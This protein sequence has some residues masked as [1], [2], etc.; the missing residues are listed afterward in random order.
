MEYTS[1]VVWKSGEHLYHETGEIKSYE[2]WQGRLLW[3]EE[4]AY[5]TD[6]YARKG[7]AIRAAMK[8]RD[9]RQGMLDRTDTRIEVTARKMYAANEKAAQESFARRKVTYLSAPL[10]WRALERL[11]ATPAAAFMDQATLDLIKGH[12]QGVADIIASRPRSGGF[13]S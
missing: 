5:C 6:V 8:L 4:V 9:R 12:R 2:G 1:D 7:N 11:Q 3:G 10:L 13:R